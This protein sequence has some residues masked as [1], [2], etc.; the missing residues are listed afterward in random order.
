[1]AG[2]KRVIARASI[3]SEVDERILIAINDYYCLIV[4][5][6][7]CLFYSPRSRTAVQTRMKQLT[8]AGYT[9]ALFLNRGSRAGSSPIVYRLNR[10]GRRHL[11]EQDIPIPVRFR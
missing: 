1:M 8:D 7:L 4:D 5:Q 11:A 3:P 10:R 9:Q 6:I 2:R